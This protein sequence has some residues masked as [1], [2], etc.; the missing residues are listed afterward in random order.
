MD[1]IVDITEHA[2]LI[3]D[4]VAELAEHP[5]R[6]QLLDPAHPWI[7]I[8]VFVGMAMLRFGPNPPPAVTGR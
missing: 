1:K 2:A 8:I 4:N 3:A 6:V 7:L 5:P